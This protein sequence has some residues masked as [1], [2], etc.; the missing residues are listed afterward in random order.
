MVNIK[1]GEVLAR[2]IAFFNFIS[3]SRQITLSFSF[4]E[5]VFC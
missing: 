2:R 3:L 5:I 1:L 4:L